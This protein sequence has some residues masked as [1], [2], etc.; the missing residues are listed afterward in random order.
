MLLPLATAARLIARVVVVD[1]EESEVFERDGLN[2]HHRASISFVQAALGCT[3][4]V[5]T[6]EED[7]YH[8]LQTLFQIIDLCDYLSFN[9]RQDGVIE[10][11]TSMDGVAHDDN[12]IGRAAKRLQ[13]ASGT[14]LGATAGRAKSTLH[15]GYRAALRS[16]SI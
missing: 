16:V 12:L 3:L 8:E 2:L 1:V 7:G 6:L 9:L 13:Q 11:T 5:P 14:H 10:L 4:R 15:S